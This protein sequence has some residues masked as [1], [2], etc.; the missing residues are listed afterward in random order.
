VASA[1]LPV[2]SL[3]WYLGLP[4]LSG[5]QIP[6]FFFFFFEMLIV[7]ELCTIFPALLRRHPQILILD[8]AL[9]DLIS[10]NTLDLFP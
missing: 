2:E 6:F 10:V 3:Q 4:A 9:A 5:W 7:P 8:A 1:A